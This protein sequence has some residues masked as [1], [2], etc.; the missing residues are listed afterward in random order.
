[1]TKNNIKSTHSTTAN[2]IEILD[3]IRR[4]N[5]ARLADVIDQF[6]ISRSTAYTHL[7]TLKQ[8]GFIVRQD[9][10]YCIGLRFRE[11]SVCARNR[12]PSFQIVKKKMRELANETDSEIEFLVEETGRVNLVY[13]SETVS[14]DRVRLY[15]HNT[16]AGKAILTEM[17]DEDVREALDR[18]GM[19]A[20]TP[21]TITAED[22]LFAQLEDIKDQGYAYNDREC[23]EGY[24]GIGAPIEGINGSILGA[25]TIGGPVYR[26]E[27]ET[28]KNEMVDLLLETVDDIETT[29][30]SQRAIISAELANRS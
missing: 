4:T 1:M 24:H 14:H 13:H 17:P 11:F 22:E 9:G 29:I 26:V 30:E 15:L 18:W 5:G 12:K 8:K 27:E 20:Q 23:F 7:N 3:F 6:D 10:Q 21:N 28:L 25:M 2:A 16:A 19:P